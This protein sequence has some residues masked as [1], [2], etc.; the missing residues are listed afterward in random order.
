MIANIPFWLLINLLF[1][2][3]DDD[4]APLKVMMCL[5]H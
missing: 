5:L 4:A 1:Y 3:N 2:V